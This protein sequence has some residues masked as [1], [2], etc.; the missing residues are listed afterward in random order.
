M[1][2]SRRWPRLPIARDGL[3]AVGRVRKS[4]AVIGTV[5]ADADVAGSNPEPGHSRGH[6]NAGTGK[7]D[8]ERSRLD[9]FRM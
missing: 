4:L 2:A 7:I 5:S 1:R 3:A 8:P 6:A 9:C